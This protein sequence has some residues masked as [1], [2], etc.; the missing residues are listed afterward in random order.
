[1]GWFVKGVGGVVVVGGLIVV[2]IYIN[3]EDV[4]YGVVCWAKY[5]EVKVVGLMDWEGLFLGKS[6]NGFVQFGGMEYVL[7]EVLICVGKGVGVVI[8]NFLI[9]VD[10]VVV[11]DVKQENWEK[12]VG[13]C[14]S[15]GY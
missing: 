11:F 14:K 2:M 7:L 8:F 5:S 3:C 13:W 15:F 12:L 4:F 10:L 9:W 6:G 1:M